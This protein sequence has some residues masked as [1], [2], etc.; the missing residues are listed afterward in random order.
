MV[1]TVNRNMAALTSNQ[2]GTSSCTEASLNTVQ[3]NITL[4]LAPLKDRAHLKLKV[5]QEKYR[6]ANL[7]LAARDNIMIV[8]I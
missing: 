2:P 5:A 4:V 6:K 8:F 7:E 3:E 1:N